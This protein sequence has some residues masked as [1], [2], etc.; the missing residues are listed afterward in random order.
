MNAD[1]SRPIDP[2]RGPLF[3]FALFK[4]APDRFFWFARYH[5]ITMDGFG[6]GLVARR[7]AEVYTPLCIGRSTHAERIRLPGGS[8]ESRTPS[9]GASSSSLRTASSGAKSWPIGHRPVGSRREHASGTSEQL[10]ARDR[11][12]AGPDTFGR[13]AFTRAPHGYRACTQVAKRS[14]RGD[15]PASSHGRQRTWCWGCR[16]RSR[17]GVARTIARHERR[18]FCHCACRSIPP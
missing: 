7:L 11:V 12:R 5:H 14:R 3:G 13:A 10:S 2:M 8:A 4:A 17:E 15:F 1:L 18:M 9:I 16:S 6:M